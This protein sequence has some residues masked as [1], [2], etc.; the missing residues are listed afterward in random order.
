MIDLYPD[1][2]CAPDAALFANADWQVLED[3]LEHIGTGYFVTRATLAMRRQGD[4]W[5]WPLH[6]SEKSWCGPRS[7]REAF[8]AAL[9]AFGIARDAAL[10][11]SFAIG[12]GL[13]T[14]KIGANAPDDFIVLADL[15]RPRPVAKPSARKRPAAPEARLGLR[16]GGPPNGPVPQQR[17]GDT[18]SQR[19]VL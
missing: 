19:A 18:V 1:D 7:F 13:N 6:L 4:L 16:R 2:A 5:E 14:G 9:D 8:L 10:A 3:G 11:Q 17:S 15:V 12:F